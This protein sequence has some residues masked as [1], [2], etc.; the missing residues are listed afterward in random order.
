MEDFVQKP[1]GFCVQGQIR[2]GYCLYCFVYFVVE[3]H[4]VT[5]GD[6]LFVIDF[7]GGSDFFVGV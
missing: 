1:R 3:V 4:F 5:E 7:G 6:F 2:V